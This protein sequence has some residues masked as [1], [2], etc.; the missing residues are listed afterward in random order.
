M[1]STECEWCG[2]TLSNESNVGDEILFFTAK[3]C[4][5]CK[6]ILPIINKMMLK[7]P[8]LKIIDIDIQQSEAAKWGVKN[9][10]A[11]VKLKNGIIT[12][13]LVGA[14]SER[15]IERFILN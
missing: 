12:N 8:Y 5:P 1:N 7:F 13:M 11:L 6:Q 15:D 4:G 14:H 9:I 3:W 10:P 2:S